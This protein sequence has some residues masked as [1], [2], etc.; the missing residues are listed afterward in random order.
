MNAKGASWDERI[1]N[2][3]PKLVGAW[4]LV[5][6]TPTALYAIRDPFGVRPLCLGR[7][8]S[9][10]LVASETSALDTIGAQ[11][12]RDVAPGEVLR[13]DDRGPV[14]IA[15]LASSDRRGLCI[16]EHVYLASASSRLGG[17]SVYATRERM[18]EILA[19]EHPAVADVVIPV[20]DS[21]IPA[22]VGYARRERHPVPGGADQEPLHRTHVH[23]A[24]STS[25]AGTTSRS[26][27][28]R[29]PTCSTASA[30]SS[31]TIRSCAATP[32]VRSSIFSAATA[33]RKCTCAS[34]RRRSSTSASSVSTWRGAASSSALGSTSRA[35]VVH[36]G[37]DT[38]GYLSLDGM[39]A[40]T[41]GTSR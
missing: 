41:G 31:S 36:I 30:S 22:A 24:D 34:A 40:A 27:T 23:P 17:V 28:T 12:V 8:G 3:L 18:G 2:A 38:L 25:C 37:A 21:A 19:D 1:T 15:D 5:L 33:R 16:F 20:P 14:T 32:A 9:S 10:W 4:S 6:L 29:C 35:S 26:S 13:I 11:F 7:K 39:V